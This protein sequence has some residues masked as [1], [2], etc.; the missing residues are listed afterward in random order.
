MPDQRRPT[1]DP[2]DYPADEPIEARARYLL[3]YAVL[4]PSSHNSQPW[5]FAVDGD[6]VRVY[7]D[8]SRAL[9]V[10]DPDGRE[11]DLSVGCAVENLVVAAERFGLGTKVAYV[12]DSGGD[13]EDDRRHVA[14]VTLDP[15]APPTDPEPAL[16]DAVLTRRTNH[17]PFEDRGV[18]T[19][20]RER[21]ADCVRG[22]DVGLAF[23]DDAESRAA[24]A[25]LQVRADDRQFENR[26]Y[27]AELA[28][29]IGSGALGANW[30]TAR[31]GEAAVRHLNLGDREGRKNSRLV[32]S[33][34]L[35]AVVTGARDDRRTRLDAGRTFERVALAAED[36]GL[37]VH[38]LSQ[39]LEVAP[40]ATELA[41][42][43]DVDDHPLHLFRVGY[44]EADERVTPRR[45]VAEVLR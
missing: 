29:W 18:P 44:A 10:A 23:V 14:T 36:A 20:V 21:L 15:E 3:G 38:P 6:E 4:A 32:E 42:R 12:D 13:A 33:A 17:R 35:L 1:P 41:A 19:A 30:L 27:R 2:D 43:L 40:L 39:I 9:S 24:V 34:P 28:E 25:E 7:A 45:P 22:P 26:A 5:A 37:A 11:L 31:V 8:E 16:C